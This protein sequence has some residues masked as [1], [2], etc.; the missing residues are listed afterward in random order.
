MERI[1]ATL[2]SLTTAVPQ[3]V[4]DM[5]D[6][7][8]TEE[9]SASSAASDEAETESAVDDSPSLLKTT[10]LNAAIAHLASSPASG[11]AE[12]FSSPTSRSVPQPPDAA[13]RPY[14]DEQ[15]RDSF[16]P[17]EPVVS[18]IAGRQ[19]ASTTPARQ[20]SQQQPTPVPR[21]AAETNAAPTQGSP[22]GTNPLTASISRQDSSPTQ[23]LATLLADEEQTMFSS[24]ASNAVRDKPSLKTLLSQPDEV[25]TDHREDKPGTSLLSLTQKLLKGVGEEMPSTAKTAE[26]PRSLS[27]TETVESRGEEGIWPRKG[28]SVRGQT[29]KGS[30]KDKIH[31][32]GAGEKNTSPQW[33]PFTASSSDRQQAFTPGWLSVAIVTLLATILVI[34]LLILN[35]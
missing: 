5:L 7:V 15:H 16:V 28:D 20:R 33:H 25:K 11:S 2:Q 18:A 9:E 14:P 27:K 12:P 1:G 24:A 13:P 10:V 8:K 26:D 4:G 35:L 29:P 21:R 23:R 19:R 32:Q 3:A 31:A 30:N 17:Y 34:L 22:R 6:S